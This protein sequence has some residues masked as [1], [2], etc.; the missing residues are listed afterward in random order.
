[1]SITPAATRSPEL[2]WKTSGELTVLPKAFESIP[3]KRHRQ[4]GAAVFGHGG[5]DLEISGRRS[6]AALPGT[7]DIAVRLEMNIRGEI[8]I[9]GLNASAF[10]RSL[11]AVPA[12]FNNV[13]GFYRDRGLLSLLQRV[14]ARF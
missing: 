6:T 4:F 12:L 3:Q 9:R 7:A 2:S 14:F 5:R 10:G 1:M 13:A 8:N 11:A